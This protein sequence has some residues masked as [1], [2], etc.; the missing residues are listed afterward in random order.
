MP[1]LNEAETLARCI[2]KARAFL[3]RSGIVGEVVIA[4]N[5]S[6]DGSQE[7]AAVQGARVVP[8]PRRA[9]AARC[10]AASAP[11]AAATSSWAIPT[12]A[13]ISVV[14]MASSRSCGRDIN[15]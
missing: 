10:S 14:S 7:I 2:D 9:T 5:G 12:T 4:D 6:T 3:I 15:S 11:R 8:V 1:C 13:T